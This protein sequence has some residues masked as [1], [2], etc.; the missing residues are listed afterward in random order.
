MVNLN[1]KSVCP[2][3]LKV[4]DAV[5]EE[6][7]IIEEQEQWSGIF[8]NKSCKEHGFFSGLVWEDSMEAFVELLEQEPKGQRTLYGKKKQE[9]GCP[10]DCGLCEEHLQESCCVLLEVTNRCNL[11]CP[12]CF[13][14][15]QSN[16][17]NEPSIAEIQE[18]LLDMIQ[19]G[20]PFNLQLSGGEPTVREDLAQIIRLA[21]E[22]GF[23]YIQLNTNGLRIAMEEG[24]LASLKEA[25]L[26]S[27]FL[28]FDGLNETS[29][30]QL[31]GR[32]L[33][34]LKKQV[35]QT[36]QEV[37]MGVVL[38]CTLTP[39]VNLDQIGPLIEFAFEGLPVIRGVHFQPIS[40]FGRC[41]QDAPLHRITIPRVLRE[42]E[43]QTNGL[44]KKE[45]FV[46]GKAEHGLCS[47]HGSFLKKQDG[48]VRG[49]K[50]DST[51]SECSAQ[52]ARQYVAARWKKPDQTKSCC[53]DNKKDQYSIQSLDD[54]MN[55]IH[56]QTLVI[57]GMAFQ[58]ADTLDLNRLKKC[59][60]HECG[61]KGERVPFCAYNLTN[62]Y[63]ESLYRAK[64]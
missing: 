47:F 58:D 30:Q 56:S 55:L 31:R 37:Q 42:I 28:Q 43:K 60:V 36:C 4:I 39:N 48:T 27:V 6:Q 50:P 51:V 46:N 57:S 2:V 16:G 13:A 20:G 61:K 8:L 12:V 40:Y 7:T 34:D 3:C 17:N 52:A 53:C 59:I 64:G 14:S 35:I 33:L 44:L 38:V 49:N 45:D 18:S 10:Y 21:K 11:N 22:Y 23:Q 15:S 54:F 5:Y 19:T 29:Y 25:G 41:I 9:K 26:D 1:T 63:G 62:V 32:K 24:Y